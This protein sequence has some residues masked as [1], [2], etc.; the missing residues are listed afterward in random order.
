[1]IFKKDRSR[2][3][4]EKGLGDRPVERAFLFIFKT[5]ATL[6]KVGQRAES[7]VFLLSVDSLIFF[8][9]IFLFVLC[10]LCMLFSEVLPVCE[11][12]PKR[13]RMLLNCVV[14]SSEVNTA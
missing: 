2:K 10:R 9:V 5:N 4:D 8:E 6:R 3:K 11:L 14:C 12:K 1:M 7:G 13:S